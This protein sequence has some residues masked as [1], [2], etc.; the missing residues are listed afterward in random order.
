MSI[1]RKSPALGDEV[2]LGESK[3]GPIPK[4]RPMPMLIMR[5]SLALGDGVSLRESKL[6]PMPILMEFPKC[7]GPGWLASSRGWTHPS[8]SWLRGLVGL[9]VDDDGSKKR[10]ETLQ[11]S[12]TRGQ[13]RNS[14]ASKRG[15]TLRLRPPGRG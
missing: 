1:M 13:S 12:Q 8:I 10:V 14:L 6:R 4:L 5:K 3:K 9:L 15:E 2:S 11:M 7:T